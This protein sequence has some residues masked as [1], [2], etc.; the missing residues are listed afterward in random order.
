MFIYPT[1]GIDITFPPVNSNSNSP[2][3]F[4]EEIGR[5]HV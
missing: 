3:Y 5:A 4:P 1:V 2:L